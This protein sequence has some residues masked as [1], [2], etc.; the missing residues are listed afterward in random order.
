MKFGLKKLWSWILVLAM[1][2]NLVPAQAIEI[3]SPGFQTTYSDGSAQPSVDEGTEHPWEWGSIS[4]LMEVVEKRTEFSKEFKLS[5]GFNMAVV[6]PEA[7]HYEED[8]R[9]EDIDNTLH[10]VES[11]GA[12]VYQTTAGAW[13]AEFP[14]QLQEGAQIKISKNGYNVGIELIG[15][16]YSSTSEAETQGVPAELGNGQTFVITPE[17]N[18]LGQIHEFDYSQQ[19]EEAQYPE[20]ILEN[21]TSRLSYASVY[22]NTDIVYDI[23]SYQLAESVKIS[24]YD[25]TIVGY[26]YLLNTGALQPV[27]NEDGSIDLQS[28]DT[29]EIVMTISAPFMVDNSGVTSCDVTVELEETDTGYLLTCYLPTQWLASDNRAWPVAMSQEVEVSS[30]ARNIMD[31]T[32]SSSGFGFLGDNTLWVGHNLIIGTMRT[33]LKYINLPVLDNTDLIVNASLS[34]YACGDQS[35][36]TMIEAHAVDGI[37][38]DEDLSWSNQPEFD[39]AVEDYCNVGSSKHYYWNITDIAREWYTGS[40]AGVLLKMPD[41]KETATS[42]SFKQFYSAD[43]G[44][45]SLELKPQIHIIYRNFNGLESCWDYTSVA[46]SRAGSGYINNYTGNLTWVRNDLGFGGNRMLVSISHIYNTG[47]APLNVFGLGDGWQTNYHQTIAVVSSSDSGA[48]STD[49]YIWTDGDGTEHYFSKND[50]KYVDNDGLELSLTVSSSGYVITDKYG[51]TSTFDSHGRL[52]TMTNNQAE[53]SSISITYT[54]ADGMQISNITDG[55][56]RRYLFSYSNGLLSEIAYYGKGETKIASVTYDYSDSQLIAITDQDGGTSTFTYGNNELLES[57]ADIDGYKIQYTYSNEAAS[58]ARVVGIEEWDGTLAGSA[59]SIEYAHNQT[60]LTDHNGHVQIL[61]FNDWGNMISVQDDQG[62]AQF[63]GYAMNKHDESGGKGNQLTLSSKMQNTVVNQ[64]TD[65]SFEG[66]SAWSVPSAGTAALEVTAAD[67]YIGNKSLKITSNEA[68]RNVCAYYAYTLPANTACTFSAYVK[69]DDAASVCLGI[70]SP[71]AIY[72]TSEVIPAGSGWTRL[73]VTYTN[74]SDAAVDAYPLLISDTAGTAYMDCAQLELNVTASRYN[75]LENGDFS[76]DLYWS[77]ST[78]RTVLDS[79][80]TARLDE[81]VYEFTGNPEVAQSISQNVQV[82]GSEGDTF[83]LSGWAKGDS[84]PLR[85]NRQFAIIGKF[86]YTDGTTSDPF[87]AQFNPD[88]DSSI[89]WQYSAQVMVAQKDYSAIEVKIAY[90]YNVNTVYFDGIQLFKEEFGN[91]YTYDEDGNVISVVDL[92]KQL[93]TYEYD[94]NSN[95]EMVKQVIGDT[96]VTKMTYEYDDYHNVTKATSAEGLVYEFT[97][98]QWGNNTSVSISNGSNRVTSSAAYSDDGNILVSTTDALAKVTQYG[99]NR[100]TNVLE[101]VQYPEDTETTRTE[102][103]YDAMYRLASIAAD[104]DSGYSLNANYTYVDDLLVSLETNSAVYSFSYGAFSQISAIQVGNQTLASYTYTD[105]QDR[106]LEMLTYGNEDFV[107]YTY[108]DYGRITQEIYEDGD[109]VTYTYNNSGALATVTDSATGITTTYYY[110]FTDRRMKCVETGEDYYHSVGY[111]YDSLNN[112]TMLVET[113][114]GVE[115]TTGYTYDEDNRVATMTQDGRTE[116][117]TYDALGRLIASVFNLGEIIETSR[118]YTYNPGSTQITEMSVAAGEYQKTYSYT[119]DDN[120]NI[121]SVCWGDCEITYV[122]DSANQL[123][124]ENNQQQNKTWAWVYDD[125]GNILSRTEYVYTTGE[126]GAPVA[127]VLYA[128]GDAQ[129]GDLLTSYNGNA[130][131][132]DGVGNPLTDGT[133]T[134]TW[135]HGRQLNSLYSEGADGREVTVT[136]GYDAGG[137]RVSKTVTVQTGEVEE[138]HTHSYTSRTHSPTCTEQGYT[139][140]WCGCGDNYIG[141]YIPALGHT[142]GLVLP[143]TC[144]RCGEVEPDDDVTPILPPIILPGTGDEMM[145]FDLP[146]GGLDLGDLE[147]PQPVTTETTYSYVY[148]GGQLSEVTIAITTVK[149]DGSTLKRTETLSFTYDAS[150]APQALTWGESTYLYVVNAQGDVVAI[151]DTAGNAVV[152]YAYD[153]WGNLLSTTGSMAGTLG[154]YNPLRYRGYVYDTETGF[155]YLQSRYYDPELGRFLNADVLVSTGQGLLGNN[156]FAYCN[157]N[158]GNYSD[159]SG[160]C[161]LCLS[162]K[163]SSQLMVSALDGCCGGGGGGGSSVATQAMGAL[164]MVAAGALM[165]SAQSGQVLATKSD[166]ETR[167]YQQVLKQEVALDRVRLPHIHHIV[168]V[169]QFSGRSE[170]T[171]RQIIEMHSILKD[172]GIN[173]FVDPMNLVLVSAKTHATLHTDEYIAHVYSYISQARGSRAELYAALFFLRLEIAARDVWALGY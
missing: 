140:Y 2:I 37:W 142:Y 125:A 102:Y 70:G 31:C 27:A 108:D 7:V 44:V 40:N 84:A 103:G 134:Y 133:W 149:V 56:G 93:T 153:A 19:T 146:E 121:L 119:Y 144:L 13:C 158:P 10:G 97:Y 132:Y 94:E 26:Q 99:Y 145:S 18:T 150:G 123:V 106:Y 8:G 73:Q 64:I 21:L 165:A 118:T 35:G 115:H 157:N 152:E 92:Q 62:R 34:L 42:L 3:D 28:P 151:L 67:A 46:T 58:M 55:A 113:I 109:T 60:T 36:Y 120:G 1:A 154:E 79:S 160:M 129:W 139:F 65:S 127:T 138:N 159:P 137:M 128:Y 95:L 22:E 111:Q 52:T 57:V 114:N 112:L 101:W 82:S 76:N 78:G 117:L 48:S 23:S 43:R 155:Y 74:N 54:T 47:N 71:E 169:G 80:A 68:A 167:Q 143:R 147:L 90:D 162:N 20:T 88:A 14:Q 38:N 39:T 100:D 141:N 171:K 69:T 29:E 81:N 166:K 11:G 156:M 49:T 163:P 148:H 51:N 104:V 5:N 15:Q 59:L 33:Y 83:V 135:E 41:E 12:S 24:E 45:G 9:W 105:T 122:Y 161:G 89:N 85:D 66:N 164:G 87:T 86:I 116:V 136:Y 168:P 131:T 63:A 170:E 77:A 32:V 72:A 75:L 4:I 126:L 124:R 6:Y 17:Q 50:D 172:N 53:A 173:R 130:I 98:D 110:D 16:L 61:Q 96:T 25:A 30:D 107:R 91:S